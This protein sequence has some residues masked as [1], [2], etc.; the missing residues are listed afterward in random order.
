LHQGNGNPVPWGAVLVNARNV[1][2]PGV[3]ITAEIRADGSG[4]LFLP[5][6]I[7]PGLY[8]LDLKFLGDGAITPSTVKFELIV[9]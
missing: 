4:G 5:N 6:R 7:T 3:P 1:A 8:I 2:S 9:N